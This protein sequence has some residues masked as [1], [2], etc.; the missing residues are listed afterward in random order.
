MTQDPERS[1]RSDEEK[2]SS[3]EPVFL[4]YWS[5]LV[6]Y[7]RVVVAVALT[8][9]GLGALLT[10]LATPVY[11]ATTTLHIERQGPDVLTFKDVLGSDVTGYHEY[12]NTQYTL[13][14]SR[15]VLKL[16]AA[17]LDLPNR[18]EYVNRKTSPV[19][20]LMH[21]ARTALRGGGRSDGA[22]SAR[23]EASV[24]FVQ[25]G[26]SVEPIR[27]SRLVRVS[28]AGQNPVLARDV[29]NA[30]A[31]AYLQFNFEQRY[32]TTEQAS[33]FLTKEVLRLQGEI[34]DLEQRLLQYGTE[35]E[36]LTLGDGSNDISEQALAELNSRLA[37]ARGRLA[38]AL[39]R[40]EA[41]ADAPDESI[42]QVLESS[43]INGL[44]QQHAELERR[45]GQ[46]AE[47]FKPGWPALTEVAEELKRA[48]ERL[49]LEAATVARQV[50]E[51]ARADHR[52]LQHEVAELEVQVAV[53]RREVRRVNMDT[54]QYA[55]L[56]REIE[57]RRDVLAQ[58]VARQSQT[59]SSGQLRNN[60][61]VS[62]VRVVDVAELPRFA[63]SPRKLRSL[64]LYGL[65]GLFFGVA[66]AFVL[67]TLDNTIKIERDLLRYAPGLAIL[68]QVPRFEPLKL[69][70]RGD[71]AASAEGATPLD[72]ASHASP[73]SVFAEAFKN[74]RTSLLLASADH[75]P[76]HIV[77]TSCEPSAGKSTTSINL[78]IVLTQMERRVLL[79]DADLRRPRL[80][81][82][83]GL[84]N[85]VGLSSYLS[86]N[87]PADALA[88]E[89]TIPGLDVVTAG[90]VPPNPSELLD[91][92][93]LLSLLTGL[94][95]NGGYD[96]VIFDSP[97]A[98]QVSD[99]RILS[100]RVDATILVVRARYTNRT[101][102]AQGLAKLRQAR[103]HLV[104]A[105]LN[106]VSE[107]PGYYYKYYSHEEP[108]ESPSGPLR[109]V[110]G[111][112]LGLARRPRA[113]RARKRAGER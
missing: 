11:R 81:K 68:A 39:A 87:V 33:E 76:R 74:L 20:R 52:R 59:E 47:R 62:N 31:D 63:S 91:S 55:S 15:R 89:T 109:T 26:L 45:H 7:R 25:A 95:E 41:L 64:M 6:D 80:H 65:A 44:K 19:R 37:D 108:P 97:P 24:L 43:L 72:L 83:L 90:P 21:W 49:R 70:Q 84:Q 98:L 82:T 48:E 92:P 23:E 60:Q 32:T 13:L 86:G 3:D 54:V 102:L 18:P 93:G 38:A 111:R 35:K 99:S 105:V 103:A 46:M 100:S 36:L 67:H 9:L 10:L 66:A 58:L 50:R 78:A 96:F 79:I 29:A 34:K 16:A 88:H 17:R 107:G 113:S 106:G 101:A 51:G 2:P 22:P 8:V 30:V 4:G 77:V 12:Y 71:T 85:D 14:S 42:P 75:P 57:S 28:F 1:A 5:V 61:N 73:R 94:E 110:G 104:G 27:L 40:D 112:L 56:E 69:V 53:H